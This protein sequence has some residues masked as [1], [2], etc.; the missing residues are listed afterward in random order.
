[1]T[2]NLV[3]ILL[4]QRTLRFQKSQSILAG[5]IVFHFFMQT[6]S[7]Q[8]DATLLGKWRSKDGQLVV[9]IANCTS[10]TDLCA[11]VIEDTPPPGEKNLVGSIIVKDIKVDSKS[12]WRG[13]FMDGKSEYKASINLK[14]NDLVE[15]KACAF[16]VLCESLVYQ[17]IK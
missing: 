3:T 4:N 7:A 11:T 16:L 5:V 9:N 17:R 1:M 13:I 15:F 2:N 14:N 6:V 8:S 12:G 10:T